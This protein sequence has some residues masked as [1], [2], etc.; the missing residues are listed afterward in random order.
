MKVHLIVFMQYEFTFG[1]HL[2]VYFFLF[3]YF[4]FYIDLINNDI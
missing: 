2:K 1:N 4:G 3:P